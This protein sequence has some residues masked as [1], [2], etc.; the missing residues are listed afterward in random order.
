MLFLRIEKSINQKLFINQF[1]INQILFIMKKVL[2]LS[3]L[4]VLLAC[5]FAFN[6]CNKIKDATSKEVK[7]DKVSVKFENITV[8][9]AAEFLRGDGDRLSGRF[10]EKVIV[11]IEDYLEILTKE[12]V[13]NRT[14][15]SSVRVQQPYIMLESMDGDNK[16]KVFED[17]TLTC[18]GIRYAFTEGRYELGTRYQNNLT[19]LQGFANL[20]LEKMF[21]DGKVELTIQGYT[22]VPKDAKLKLTVVMED[23]KFVVGLL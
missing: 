16:D 11:K 5:V 2:S 18:T 3:S 17:L 8:K 20:V 14:S 22:N 7:V 10:D 6:S 21:A 23:V 12:A 15:V 4:F 9:E 13:D 1:F 19:A